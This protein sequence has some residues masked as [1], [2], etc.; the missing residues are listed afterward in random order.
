MESRALRR[1]STS[2]VVIPEAYIIEHNEQKRIENAMLEVHSS[3]ELP[4][5]MP[6]EHLKKEKSTDSVIIIE[7]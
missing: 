7:I 2:K 1:K 6:Y 4:Y 3:K 5:P